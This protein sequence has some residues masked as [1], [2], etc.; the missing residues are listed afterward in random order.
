[1]PVE[2]Q[3]FTVVSHRDER[4][5]N[6]RGASSQDGPGGRRQSLLGGASFQDGPGGRGRSLLRVRTARAVVVGYDFVSP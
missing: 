2:H 3:T 1:M 6:G 4:T 5:G